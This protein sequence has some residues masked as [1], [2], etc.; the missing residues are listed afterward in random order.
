VNLQN[1]IE[2]IKAKAEY[3]SIFIEEYE[4][5]S[6]YICRTPTTG[7]IDSWLSVCSKLSLNAIMMA[8]SIAYVTQV[9]PQEK[10]PED[11]AV[12]LGDK[13][14]ADVP[15]NNED[16]KKLYEESANS[17]GAVSFVV[18]DMWRVTG[19]NPNELKRMTLD[20][21]MEMYKISCLISGKTPVFMGE[22]QPEQ[23]DEKEVTVTEK[24]IQRA[25]EA[26]DKMNNMSNVLKDIDLSIID[27]EDVPFMLDK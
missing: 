4:S 12:K 18:Y 1:T 9:Y 27:E 25:K 7:E 5:G 17:I 8:M 21:L 11:I 2:I 6:L 14:M 23:Q 3:G 10:M 15:V 13:I 19:V 26:A 22:E 16:L 24:D 20:E